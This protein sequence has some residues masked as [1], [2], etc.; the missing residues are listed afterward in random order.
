ML[1]RPEVDN[2]PFLSMNI[3][4]NRADILYRLGQY[5]ASLEDLDNA[6][7]IAYHFAGPL[8]RVDQFL[9]I[10]MN[11]AEMKDFD[12]ARKALGEARE[13]SK[14]LER[15]NDAAALLVVEAEISRREWEA[16]SLQQL[17]RAQNQ[18]RTS[19]RAAARNKLA[20]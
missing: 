6:R 2:N 9:A 16:G 17:K 4:R 3:L 14:K 15:P 5:A 7:K 13:L 1:A 19:H 20:V 18:H 12:S 10:A 8:V 11:H